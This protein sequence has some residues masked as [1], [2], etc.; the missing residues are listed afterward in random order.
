MRPALLIAGNFLRENRWAIFLLAVWSL[1]SGAAAA[2]TVSG[3]T[4]DALFFLKQQAAY[5]VFFTVFLAASALH[6]QRRS[7]R[8]LAVLAKGIERR[9]YLAGIVFGFLAVAAIYS[10]TLGLTGAWTF[11]LARI[12]PLAVLPMMLMLFVAS[13]LAGTVALFF[14]TFMSP[15]LTLAATSLAL[16]A[17]AF[18]G[19]ASFLPA[20][21]LLQTVMDFNFHRNTQVHWAAVGWACLEALLLWAA[22]SLIFSRRDVAVSVE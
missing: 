8:I 5:S 19:R 2:V 21:T 16:G 1:V 10:V 9:E 11:S 18:L 22:A 17:A 3:S 20:Y 12:G 14:S 13:A 7:R 15:L 6:N 4:E